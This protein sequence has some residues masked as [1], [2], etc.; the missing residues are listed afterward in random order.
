MIAGWWATAVTGPIALGIDWWYGVPESR[1]FRLSRP[2]DGIA[3]G[4]MALLV[5]GI[6]AMARR[7]ERSVE[8]VRALDAERQQRV[9]AE[10]ASRRWAEEQADH[11]QAAPE[12]STQLAQ[13]L[14]MRAVA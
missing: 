12:L 4:A 13:A 1:S 7:V 3:L 6:T 9:A 8:D 2:G 14:T 10:A 11:V 5:V